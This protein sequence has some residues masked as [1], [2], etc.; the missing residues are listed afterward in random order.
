MI[1]TKND[2]K[3]LLPAYQAQKLDQ[4]NYR[5]VGK[6]IASCPDCK[7]E[8]VLLRSMADDSVPDPGEAFWNKMPLRVYRAVQRAKK[9]RT[10][11]DL[12]W[13][14]GRI[15]L[16]RWVF[17]AA[18]AAVMLIISL[19]A[20]DSMWTPQRGQGISSSPEYLF[21]GGIIADDAVPIADITPEQ[22]DAVNTWAVNELAPIGEE[23]ASVVSA[24]ADTDIS[25]DI[26]EL[27]IN[28]AEHISNMLKQWKQE[29]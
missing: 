19:Q 1:C 12:S 29:G 23:V 5:R 15:T 22:A 17:A 11:F 2:I 9:G 16:P 3:E 28:E 13:L 10:H 4:E 18:T 27:N 20:V 8:L 26:A 21:S 6:H 25:D 7:M 14:V 24:S